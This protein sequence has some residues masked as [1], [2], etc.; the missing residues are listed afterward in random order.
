MIEVKSMPKKFS[1]C[2]QPDGHRKSLGK[3]V[4]KVEREVMKS[5]NDEW[6]SQ[7][8]QKH[9]PDAEKKKMMSGASLYMGEWEYLIKKRDTEYKSELEL[10]GA[11]V[12]KEILVDFLKSFG[13]DIKNVIDLEH[14]KKE[15]L[16]KEFDRQYSFPIM[17]S[18]EEF[19]Q[20]CNY[21]KP[22]AKQLEMVEFAF[23]GGTRLVLG[24]R[25][26]GK[27]DY[28]TILGIAYRLYLNREE[29]FLIVAK[30][31]SR[32][33]NIVN[34]INRCLKVF[35]VIFDME[36]AV[37]LNIKGH[38]GKQPNLVGLS[39]RSMAFRGNHVDYIICD[40]IITPND[41]TTKERERVK[42]VYGECQSLCNSQ[43]PNIM[44]I[45][46]PVHTKDLYAELR[47]LEDVPKYELPYG[48]IPELDIE[49]DT[50]RL[51][52]VSESDIQANY[53]LEVSN[54]NEK[55][56][57]ANVK[58]VKHFDA[59]KGCVG[60]V[61]PSMKGIDWTAF[62]CGHSVL[63]RFQVVGFVWHKAWYECVNDIKEIGIK[64]N[65][66]KLIF[67]TNGLGDYPTLLLADKGWSVVGKNSNFNKF[68]KI[69]N[70][71]V[72]FEYIDL[73]DIKNIDN[74]FI[75]ENLDFIKQTKEF[76]FDGLHDDAPDALAS[77]MLNLNIIKMT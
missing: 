29:T 3:R 62:V 69:Q 51:A 6:M 23:G 73:V 56:P 75:A 68:A 41:R 44:I 37:Q 15:A 26:Y 35:G 71:G 59:Q 12:K 9:F 36:Q 43:T 34:E 57:F 24:A 13:L 5:L 16:E 65:V 2:Y 11:I 67:E 27:T 32:V 8:L 21:P 76:C 72:H 49:L 48:S 28:I 7:W 50:L 20:K 64:L 18:F 46:Q 74:R 14:I 10:R 55:V 70:A 53:F 19:C 17:M 63:G 25:K 38:I 60:Y 54:A 58:I 33:K 66:Q 45:G 61:D 4:K 52:G 42:V 39:I 40:D 47:I 30:E 1:S 31:E 22:F 77:L